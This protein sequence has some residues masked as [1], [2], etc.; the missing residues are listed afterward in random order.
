MLDLA[1][2]PPLNFLNEAVVLASDA[3]PRTRFATCSTARLRA[4]QSGCHPKLAMGRRSPPPCVV[5]RS[6]RPLGRIKVR[7]EERRVG[8]RSEHPKTSLG[9]HPREVNATQGLATRGSLAFGSARRPG[10]YGAWWARL[11]LSSIRGTC[12][13]PGT[14]HNP[15]SGPPAA[16]SSDVPIP[17]TVPPP[18]GSTAPL[19]NLDLLFSRFLQKRFKQG[20][21]FA[22]PVLNNSPQNRGID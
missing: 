5:R 7:S 10:S 3:C 16:S 1:I 20:A 17:T 6:R 14:R 4:T 2:A 13:P 21:Q 8:S 18:I 19:P 11:A 9:W 22:K 12:L 15:L